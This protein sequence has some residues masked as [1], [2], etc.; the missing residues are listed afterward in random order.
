MYVCMYLSGDLPRVSTFLDSL[1]EP[2]IRMYLCMIFS[3]CTSFIY[4]TISEF[5][6]KLSVPKKRTNGK[7]PK[8]FWAFSSIYLG[9]R[10]VA[11]FK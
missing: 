2:T 9:F 11:G 4:V 10:L 6:L 7:R 1:P 5:E 3:A 8:V